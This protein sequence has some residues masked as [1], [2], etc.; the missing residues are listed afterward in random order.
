MSLLFLILST[1][2]VVASVHG[3]PVTPVDLDHFTRNTVGAKATCKKPTKYNHRTIPAL[4]KVH[5][6]CKTTVLAICV[7]NTGA[8]RMIKDVQP[9]HDHVFSTQVDEC[10]SFN[11][12]NCKGRQL[13]LRSLQGSHSFK[14]GCDISD[15]EI[16]KEDNSPD[17]S[18]NCVLTRAPLL[19]EI[20][21]TLKKSIPTDKLAS[22][23]Q[24]LFE[25]DKNAPQ[26]S[27]MSIAE[28][29]GCVFQLSVWL[30]RHGVPKSTSISMLNHARALILH[31]RAC[32][33]Y[34]GHGD[35]I[36]I[37]M[38][39]ISLYGLGFATAKAKSSKDGTW[40]PN[41]AD[42]T[43][44][45]KKQV[46]QLQQLAA[47]AP[48]SG[49]FPAELIPSDDMLKS[50][51]SRVKSSV[52]SSDCPS[53]SSDMNADAW[54]S[55]CFGPQYSLYFTL[56]TAG[57][58]K[59]GANCCLSGCD[60]FNNVLRMTGHPDEQEFEKSCCQMCNAERCGYDTHSV[61]RRTLDSGEITQVQYVDRSDDIGVIV[62]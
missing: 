30:L 45:Q 12:V 55:N 35:T 9:D 59:T 44:K 37:P 4:I 34:L 17:F 32:Y 49:S 56:K 18:I 25:T 24:K 29:I 31:T 50:K 11:A 5:N 19:E 36:V 33:P 22:F 41:L 48:L 62:L 42:L 54:C 28:F 14:V 10:W 60:M 20:H 13:Y 40:K 38:A 46:Y 21:N 52:K 58:D 7:E 27:K 6:K 1:L 53:R 51:S 2:L 3:A 61:T 23:D 57:H 15:V 39:Y 8:F 43:K 26:L 47:Q 16:Q